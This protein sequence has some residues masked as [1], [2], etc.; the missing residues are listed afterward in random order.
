MKKSL[1][2]FFVLS[3]LGSSTLFAQDTETEKGKMNSFKARPIGLIIGLGKI[4]YER[5][6]NDHGSIQLGLA[7]FDYNFDSFGFSGIGITPEYRIFVTGDAIDGFYIAPFLSYDA[8]TVKGDDT[9]ATGYRY[10][11]G[12][13]AGFQWLLGK[14]ESFVIDLAF[15]GRYVDFGYKVEN[16]SNDDFEDSSFLTG[17]RPDITFAIGFAF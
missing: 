10:G 14:R 12:A 15:G 9:K 1:T 13:K 8:L 17:F 2:I 3:I 16:G 5:K 7:Y 6:L 4:A 11:G